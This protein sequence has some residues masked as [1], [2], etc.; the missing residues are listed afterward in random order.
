MRG[1]GDQTFQ[2]QKQGNKIVDP[3]EDWN[4]KAGDNINGADDVC[5]GQDRH[6][7][8]IPWNPSVFHKPAK[9]LDELG[10]VKDDL[11]DLNWVEGIAIFRWLFHNESFQ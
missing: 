8:G 2:P 6:G 3:P 9:D 7:F 1:E 5:K 11:P 4:E 10:E